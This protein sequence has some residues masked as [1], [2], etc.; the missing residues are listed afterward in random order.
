MAQYMQYEK[1]RLI[2]QE[3]L[4]RGKTQKERNRLGQFA[5]PTAL[6]RD[7]LEYGTRL[8]PENEPI[9]FL[10]PA[11]GTG[12]FYSALQETAAADRLEEATGYEIDRHFGDPAKSLW[13]H[14]PLKIHID[15]F[16]TAEPPKT[17]EEKY[18]LLICNPPYVRH[19]HI[20][21]SQ[22]ACLQLNAEQACGVKLGGLS[23]LYCYFMGIAHSWMREGGV[24]GWLIPSEFMDVNYGEALKHYLLNRVKLLRIHRF[25][26]NDVQFKD[27][28]VSS[29]VV[30]FRKEKPSVD[31]KIEFTFG[32]TL[33]KPGISRLVSTRTLQLE[34]KWTRFPV[35]GERGQTNRMTLSALFT[36]KRGLATG[37]NK[38]FILTREQI[39]LNDLPM[40]F[41]R[42]ILPSPRY[43]PVDEV[44]ADAEGNPSIDRQLFLLDC[45]LP[46]EQ[47]KE[48]YPS[49]WKYYESGKPAV[50]GRY[51]CRT[52]T[53]W[54]SQEKRPPSP[55]ICTYMGRGD[56][57]RNR[58]FR[59]I[60]NHSKATAANVYLLLYPKPF[61]ANELLRDPQAARRIWT[62]LN[63]IHMD[64]LLDEGRV[65]G[66]GLYKMEPRE[67]ANIPADDLSD[68]VPQSMQSI[69]KQLKLFGDGMF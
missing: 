17:G 4:D 54:Y 44:P 64:T 58:P 18:N 60:L 48:E 23:G 30:W 55:F 9:R 21:G 52:R 61:L 16:T 37:D 34:K 2:L 38:F 45:N 8:L 24:A 10:D 47:L 31:D 19:H 32:G 59:F 1:Q 43:L 53:P 28:L 57:K 40:K 14:T 15:D 36:I 69:P 20:S 25:D 63:R 29:A 5:T 26:P 68:F 65:Y 6:A 41:F 51:L 13:S 67:L 11:I 33:A 7:I 62:H 35:R 12:S 27:A 3:E 39:N 66:G 46:E 42:P 49:L 50:S 56:I 22:K